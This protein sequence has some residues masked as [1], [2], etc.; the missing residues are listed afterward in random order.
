MLSHIIPEKAAQYD[1]MAKEASFS[2]LVGGI[3]YKCDCVVGL[4]VG[5]NIGDF[6]IARTRTDGAE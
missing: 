3:H 2:R 6:A 4:S 5:K 1:A